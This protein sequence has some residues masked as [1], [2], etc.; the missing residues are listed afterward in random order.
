MFLLKN[1]CL[2]RTQAVSLLRNYGSEEKYKNEIIGFNSRLDDIQA[3][4]LSIKLKTL[5]ADNEKRMNIARQ[6]LDRIKNPKFKLPYYN[7]SNNHVFYAFVIEV[8]DRDDFT[9]FLDLIQ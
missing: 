7:G 1:S 6:Y 9:K 3:A 4:F 8:E 5:D 2:Y